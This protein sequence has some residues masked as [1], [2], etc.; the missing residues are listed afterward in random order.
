MYRLFESIRLSNGKFYRL[1]L[2]QIRINHSFITIFKKQPSWSLQVVLDSSDVPQA[3]LY[4]CRVVYDE[5]S[6]QIEFVP[7]SMKPIQSLKLVIDDAANYE[8]KW[9]DRTQL[10][11]AFVNKGDCDDILIVKNGLITDSLFA[12][13][14][15]YKDGNW[16]TPK[17][18]LL[19]GTMRQ[20]LLQVNRIEEADITLDNFRTYKYFKLINALF[21]WDGLE[22]DVSKIR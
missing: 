6:V 18:Y 9:E 1:D 16:F 15:F 2:H 5:H 3:G 21:E 12:N 22:T 14:V 17:S 7:Y 10:Q 13:I 8:H 20:Y 19:K 11:A 4:K